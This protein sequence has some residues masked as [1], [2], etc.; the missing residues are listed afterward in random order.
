M[1][2]RSA[3]RPASP[4]PILR[5]ER[6]RAF[7]SRLILEA[8]EEVFAARG[9]QGA[10]IEEI[11]ARAEVAIATLYNMFGSKEAIFAALVEY[12]QNECFEQ[13][14]TFAR[15]GSTPRAQVERLVEAIF[16]YFDAHQAAFRI[17]VGATHGFPWHIRSSLGERSFAKYQELLE[18]LASLV[19][20]AVRQG[21]YAAADDDPT[22]LAAAAMGVLNGLLTRRHTGNA[23]AG[24]DDEIARA[25]ALIARLLG[26]SAAA[27]SSRVRSRPGTRRR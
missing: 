7:R 12:R 16:R 13:V 22:R 26:M 18:L 4:A 14:R 17:Y 10:S 5:R 25:N 3:V 11:A 19:G 8:A 15:T 20:V 2:A 21:A 6:E 27:K 1:G 9:F 23:R 24:L